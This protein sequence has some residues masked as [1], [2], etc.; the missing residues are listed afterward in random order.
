MGPVP[1]NPPSG[2]Q[3][4]WAQRGLGLDPL[5]MNWELVFTQSGKYLS[6]A[7]TKQ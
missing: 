4:R 7:N 5:L 3:V 6:F 1:L 2:H